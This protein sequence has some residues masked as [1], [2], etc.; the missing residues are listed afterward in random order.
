MSTG[1]ML[2]FLA[3]V[4]IIAGSCA[5]TPA[6]LPGVDLCSFHRL[7]G[8]PC[9]GCGLTRAICCISHGEFAKAWAYHPFGYVAYAVIIALLLRPLIAWLL[10]RW[11]ERVLHWRGLGP[12]SVYT[13]VAMVL[14]GF[15]RIFRIL[16]PSA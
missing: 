11:E 1:R 2:G 14:F 6:T 9:P 12:L 13:A 3:A 5:F 15:W 8:L 10:P 4:T 16:F 7:T